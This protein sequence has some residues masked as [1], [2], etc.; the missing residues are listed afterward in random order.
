MAGLVVTTVFLVTVAPGASRSWNF[1]QIS[2]TTTR[3]I[4]NVTSCAMH[5]RFPIENGMKACRGRPATFA[6]ANCSGSNRSGNGPQ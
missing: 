3:S 6:M 5:C 1:R 2:N 4:M